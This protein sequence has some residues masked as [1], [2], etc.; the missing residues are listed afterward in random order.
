[1]LVLSKRI[2]PLLH[3]TSKPT[4]CVFSG[5]SDILDSTMKNANEGNRGIT[6]LKDVGGEEVEVQRSVQYL[7][8]PTKSQNDKK[9]YK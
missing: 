5:I 3:I 7:T 9:E 6:S 8:S 2:K 4:F 1:M